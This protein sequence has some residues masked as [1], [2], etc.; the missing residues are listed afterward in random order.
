MEPVSFGQRTRI[1]LSAIAWFV[2]LIL[3]LLAIPVIAQFPLWV[4]AIPV[5]A[6]VLLAGIYT[7]LKLI[8]V[9]RNVGSGFLRSCAVLLMTFGTLLAAPFYYAAYMVDAAPTVLPLV[10]LTDG[11]KDVVFQGMQHIGSESFYKSV[12]FD[13]ENALAEGY[14]LFYEGIMPSPDV[15]GADE[16]FGTFMGMKGGL[17]ASYSSMAQSCGITFQ[18]DYFKPLVADAAAHPE[19]NITA[20]VTHA[21]MKAEY[22]RLVASDPQFAAAI[23]GELK[24]QEKAGDFDIFALFAKLHEAGTAGQQQLAGIICRG[25]LNYVVSKD[26]APS[27]KGRIILD[28]RNAHLAKAIADSPAQKIYVTYGAGHL[29]GLVTELQKLDP[30]WKITSVRWVRAM[31]NPEDLKGKLAGGLVPP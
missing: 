1:G 24:Q 9:R 8:I 31:S 27:A 15:P 29:P 26:E 23:A 21:D 6:A 13:L 18:L 22:D 30:A 10:R 5:A 19:R 16:W 25:I 4:I 2:L 17:S 14:V 20:D 12:V 3:F 11:K 7:V 28:Y